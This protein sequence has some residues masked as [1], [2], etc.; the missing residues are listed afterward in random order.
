M[1]RVRSAAKHYLAHLADKGRAAAGIEL[2]LVA[3]GQAH[4]LPGHPPPRAAPAVQ[5][6]HKGIRRALGTKPKEKAALLVEQLRTIVEALPRSAVGVRDRA[7]LGLGFIGAFRR[8]ELV[9]LDLD[10]L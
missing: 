10:D 9:A 1:M 6:E 7:L 2:A 4:Q 8:S 3:I 5:E